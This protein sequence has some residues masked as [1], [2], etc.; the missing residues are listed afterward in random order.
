M[1]KLKDNFFSRIIQGKLYDL[2]EEDLKDSGALKQALESKTNTWRIDEF[3]EN[4]EFDDLPEGIKIGDIFVDTTY[5]FSGFITYINYQAKYLNVIG[6]IDNGC[7]PHAFF[8]H[9]S[10][11]TDEQLKIGTQL[12]KHHYTFETQGIPY[13]IEV[14][15]DKATVFSDLEDMVEYYNSSGNIN[16]HVLSVSV[17][18]PDGIFEGQLVGMSSDLILMWINPFTSGYF[19]SLVM[20][21]ENPPDVTLK[22]NIELI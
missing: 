21:V 5:A 9:N 16:K 17:K 3:I 1:A 7:S 8:L 15:T 4:G 18:Q 22:G 10:S 19:N 6:F 14:I 12:Y 2:T 11:W 13:D 20:S